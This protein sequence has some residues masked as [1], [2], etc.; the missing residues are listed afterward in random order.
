MSA[1]SDKTIYYCLQ[2]EI[3]T[4][5]KLAQWAVNYEPFLLLAEINPPVSHCAACD[6]LGLQGGRADMP[7]A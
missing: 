4:W 7:T 2:K 1:V 5:W 3:M 6:V